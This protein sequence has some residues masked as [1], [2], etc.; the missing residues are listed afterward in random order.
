MARLA[1]ISSQSSFN[2][3]AVVNLLLISQASPVGLT[4]PLN[5]IVQSILCVEV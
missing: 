4:E 3:A 5:V 2:L 1:T